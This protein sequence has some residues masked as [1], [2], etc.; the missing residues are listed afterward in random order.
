MTGIGLVQAK[1]VL[2]DV[3]GRVASTLAARDQ[4]LRL[5]ADPGSWLEL[6]EPARATL[7][8]LVRFASGYAPVGCELLLAA[9]VPAGRLAAAGAGRIVLR[10]QVDLDAR[11]EAWGENV[12][13]LRADPRTA[14]A[15]LATPEVRD[16]VDAFSEAR[17]ALVFDVLGEG[18]EIRATLSTPGP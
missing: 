4:H 3:A 8:R 11:A 1:H 5:D 15:L 9:A 14:G 2:S 7:A 10:W 18:E 16:L 12:V 6:A 13:P 17:T